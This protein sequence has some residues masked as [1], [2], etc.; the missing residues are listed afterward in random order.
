MRVRSVPF[1]QAVYGSFPF[2][3][4]GYA[5]LAQ[6]PGCR[7]EWVSELR[8]ACQ[9]YGERPAG[10]AEAGGL[11]ALRLAAG[12]WMIVRPSEQGR[13]DQ[14]RPGALAFHALF[15]SPADYRRAD[16]DPFRFAPA[17]GA[18]WTAETRALPRGTCA[19]V[20]GPEA[21]GD[22]RVAA[23]VEALVRRRPV[24]LEADGP[25]DGLA[26][27]VWQALPRHVRKRAA[28]A[29]WAFRAAA[30]FDLLA[31]PRRRAGVPASG[32]IER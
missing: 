16:Y 5:V 19:L 27:Q 31:V 20:P 11:F 14:G 7:P 30:G 18:V 4:R 26:R 8:A 17:L 13:D 23:T 2:W 9:R 25:I 1:E 15:V 12:P 32:A 21:V 24:V 6:S 29:T 3:D 10:A 22:P 28:V